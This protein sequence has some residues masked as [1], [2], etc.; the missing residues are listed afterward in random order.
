M[1]QC[2]NNNITGNSANYNTWAGFH[3]NLCDNNNI[4]NNVA[5]N[6]VGVIY[7]SIGIYLN[8]CNFNQV[9]ENTADYNT[10]GIRLSGTVSIWGSHNNTIANN[11]VSYNEMGIYLYGDFGRSYD[12]NIS[13]NVV[14]NNLEYGIRVSRSPQNIFSKNLVKDN[15]NIGISV[16]KE[17]HNNTFTENLILNNN[18]IGL[19]IAYDC[20][21][22]L[23]YYNC[24]GGNGINAEDERTDNEW[25]NGAYG[26]YWDDYTGI[27]ANDD[28]IGDTPYDVLPVGTSVDNYPLMTCPFSIPQGGGGFPFEMVILIA[29]ISGGA[30]ILLAVIL[31]IRKKR[32]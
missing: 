25:D 5:N 4:S 11:E 6:N 3:L 1:E 14:L 23:V 30:V 18:I 24:F 8:L 29:S 16:W 2:I 21:W 26:N 9:F 10:Y 13:G 17:S 12:N 31:I 7:E 20:Y 27:D 19:K 22:N 15:D 28:S 32:K